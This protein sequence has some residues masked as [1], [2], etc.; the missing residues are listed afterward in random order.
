[1]K[2]IVPWAAPVACALY[3][4]LLAPFAGGRPI[5][6]H[7]AP[8]PHEAVSTAHAPARTSSGG[9]SLQ[10]APLRR[11]FTMGE[12]VRYR[13]ESEVRSRLDVTTGPATSRTGG[14][15]RQRVSGFMTATVYSAEPEEA[16]VGYRLSDLSL[17]T[18][19]DRVPDDPAVLARMEE[20]A[21]EE[22]LVAVGPDARIRRY[23]FP[24]GMGEATRGLLVEL[25]QQMELVVP[26]DSSAVWVA[27]QEDGTGRF[28]ARYSAGAVIAEDGRAC[29]RVD[30]VKQAYVEVSSPL[31][32]TAVPDGRVQ[33]WLDAESGVW[34]RI[35]VDEMLRLDGPDMPIVATTSTRATWVQVS[36][37][38]HFIGDAEA[39]ARIETLQSRG[40]ASGASVPRAEAGP[41]VRPEEEELRSLSQG[42]TVDGLLGDLWRLQAGRDD[43]GA[44]CATWERLWALL[45]VD[46]L[47]VRR[48]RSLMRAGTL[49]VSMQS[50]LIEALGAAGTPE[51]Q[52]ALLSLVEDP[53]LSSAA[54]GSALLA[55]CGL[56]RPTRESEE[57]LMGKAV[58]RREEAS[59]RQAFLGLGAFVNRLS[60]IDTGRSEAI[61]SFLLSNETRND[62]PAWRLVFLDG[63]GNTGSPRCLEAVLRRATDDGEEVRSHSL[64]ALRLI[65]DPRVDAR[66][67][68]ALDGDP[69]LEVRVAA[70]RS[71]SFRTTPEGREAVRRAA[72][73]P[74]MEVRGLA[75]ES[76]ASAQADDAEARRAIERMSTQDPSAELRAAALDILQRHE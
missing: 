37:T 39:A 58:G 56:R 38:L 4:T 30:R 32:L 75:L 13:M 63:L 9:P 25:I 71:L 52:R 48:A 51:A 44:E 72:S 62:D 16:L 64:M 23:W 49:D 14:A 2:R 70:A 5:V 61:L 11:R 65:Q 17:R 20:E 21:E 36:M 19:R 6:T 74:D 22:V 7:G 1:M 41:S 46:E 60:G 55:L 54:R 26:C 12:A 8:S 45:A 35:E 40:D 33:G 18:E 28:R 68:E 50:A 57:Y 27:D 47:A 24:G 15:V 34:R 59:T 67:M 43:G 69:S 31:G 42:A 29:V 73:H 76:L 3:L 66:L 53:T 10:T